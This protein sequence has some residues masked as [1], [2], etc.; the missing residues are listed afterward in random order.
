[1][2][3]PHHYLRS[4]LSFVEAETACF[5]QCYQWGHQ[6]HTTNY[7]S[8]WTE[9]TQDGPTCHALVGRLSPFGPISLLFYLFSLF[10]PAHC[11][12]IIYVKQFDLMGRAQQRDV[13]G[14]TIYMFFCHFERQFL[15]INK[16]IADFAYFQSP[17][18]SSSASFF[19]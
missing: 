8:I 5:S 1:M 18:F 9:T 19:S 6:I 10:E 16:K 12:F 11:Y 4:K 15:M 7:T 3:G 2:H 13:L 14:F 17:F